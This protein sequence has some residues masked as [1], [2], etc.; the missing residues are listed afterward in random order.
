MNVRGEIVGEELTA[1]GT[2]VN[3]EA[4]LTYTENPDAQALYQCTAVVYPEQRETEEIIEL[5]ERIREREAAGREKKKVNLPDV[6]GGKRVRYF[7]LMNDRGMILVLM[8]VLTGVL[9]Y[10]MEIQ[11][12]GQELKE[13]K[14]QMQMDYPEIVNELTLFLGAGMTIKRSFIKIARE[15]EKRRTKENLRFAYEEM[16]ITCREMESGITESESYERFGRRCN[17]TQYIRL[18]AMLSQNLRKGTKGLSEMLRL[19]AVQ[20]F[21]ERK[22]R[23]KMLG[24]EAGTKLLVPMFI[25]LAIVLVIVTVP[26]FL[27]MQM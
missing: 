3:L 20:A 1:D 15:Y 13:K 4:V 11:E 10:A 22:A 2:I 7:P 25:M 24:E 6:I 9:F 23:A 17:E 8:G 16:L 26:A 14:Q 27:S 12:K 21:E 5:K 19:E 18:G